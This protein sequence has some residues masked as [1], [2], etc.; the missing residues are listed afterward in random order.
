M[1]EE[2]EARWRA[3]GLP[4]ST[5]IGA[6]VRPDP[7]ISIADTIAAPSTAT[8]PRA[9]PRLSVDLREVGDL[10]SPTTS[11]T[12]STDLEV[13]GLI[14]EGGMGRVLLARQHSLQRDVAVKTAKD[15]ASDAV[16]LAL[17]AEGAVTGQLEHP[18]IVPV[19]ALGVD[20]GGR[21]AMV[22]KRIE[23]VAWR[24]L[25]ADP[26][27]EAWSDWPGEPDDRLPGHLQIL[28][29]I[30]NA[31]HFAHSRG[32]VHRD[33]KLD[34]VLIG[35]FGD[36]Y[37]ADWGIAAK[38]GAA[39]PRLCGTPGSMAPE[40]AAGGVVD[41]RTDVYLLGAT[42]HELLTGSMRHAGPN[43]QAVVV[44]AYLSEPV[45]YGADVPADLA[46]LANRACHKDPAK[47]PKSARELRDALAKH[48]E[49]RAMAALAREAAQRLERVEALVALPELDL[50][51]R[52]E[53]DRLAAEAS[54]GFE[55]AF[56]RWPGDPA[57]RA[58]RDRLEALMKERR[59]HAASLE[60]Q[61][62]DRDPRVASRTRAIA[63]GLFSVVG[64]GI[65]TVAIGGARDPTRV[66][67][68]VYPLVMYSFVVLGTWLFRRQVLKN[69]FNRQL[70][71]A[72]HG[73]ILVMIMARAM[74]LLTDITPAQ[75]F[76]RDSFMLAATF[77]VLSITHLR[78]IAGASVCYLVSFVI[79][80]LF[81]QHALLVFAIA[82]SLSTL[83]V[84]IFQWST[85]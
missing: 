56:E 57:T 10:E 8:L 18:A 80:V 55:R 46:E 50:A 64:L 1:L 44:A 84:A 30:C 77:M 4:D 17:F 41:E 23:G 7:E 69:T 62:R 27:H 2:I 83:V 13:R 51:Q 14:G 61:A 36:V 52:A 6:T 85:R 49:H 40:M 38:V 19:H 68:V 25:A 42:M 76:A 21:P 29:Q 43:L 32:I 9:L 66:E 11:P 63:L 3:T 48:L 65:S 53:L 24:D 31:V 70:T 35:R 22:M 45:H 79:C 26:S 34:N 78:W 37:L 58:A 74:G 39:D 59:E 12:A 73:L 15:E 81:P 16:R 28:M 72:L 47:R 75:H 20:A 33:I 54:F 82:T 71:V 67:V 5:A 60:H